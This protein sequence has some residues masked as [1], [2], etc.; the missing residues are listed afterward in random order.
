MTRTDIYF[1]SVHGSDLFAGTYN[2]VFRSTDNG[3]NWT[4]VT[5]GLNGTLR[6]FAASGTNL[7]VCT[8]TGI[9]ISSDNGSIWTPVMS[10]LLNSFV[11]DLAICGT[12]LFAATAG[13]GVWKRPLS[14]MIT[15]VENTQH[16]IP[17]RFAL[18]QNYPNPFNPTTT[19]TFSIGTYSYTSLR[20][21]DVLGREVA[22]ITSGELP[23]GSYTKQ[24]NASSLPSGIYFYCLQVGSLTETKKLVLLK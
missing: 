2:K 19:I 10:G 18:G 4:E 24:W 15:D 8:T 6:S 17:T 16:H 5:N 7:F 14:E 12:N 13:A 3:T 9:F 1:L 22:T 11:N 23:A 20:V 21:Y